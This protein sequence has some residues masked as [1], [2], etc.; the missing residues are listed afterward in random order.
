MIKELR[1][2]AL[3][4]LLE[5]QGTKVDEVQQQFETPIKVSTSNPSNDNGFDGDRMVVENGDSSF[6]AIKVNGRWMKTQLEEM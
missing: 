1:D 6:L 4:Q 2:R 5:E 3:T